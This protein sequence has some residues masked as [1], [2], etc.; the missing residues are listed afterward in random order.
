MEHLLALIWN[1]LCFVA[2]HQ[3]VFGGIEYAI[4][5]GEVAS[6]R[7]GIIGTGTGD[8]NYGGLR[9]VTGV[10]CVF[11]T[12]NR[13]ILKWPMVLILLYAM[14]NTL[15]L[16]TLASLILIICTGVFF[17]PTASKKVR[18]VAE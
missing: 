17:E 13:R 3:I 7:Y 11:Y 9:L 10:I 16:T 6:M 4:S 8:P 18:W 2:I 12:I 5:S 14:V 15:S 1:Q